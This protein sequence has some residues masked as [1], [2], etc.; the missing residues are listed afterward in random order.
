MMKKKLLS[1]L[2]MTAM[3]VSMLAGCGGDAKSSAPA[4]AGTD[5]EPAKE[6]DSDGEDNAK[7][8]SAES[9]SSGEEV[10]P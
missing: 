7:E 3:T 6:A 10:L 4:D 9:E 8:G 2:L 1:G 5:P